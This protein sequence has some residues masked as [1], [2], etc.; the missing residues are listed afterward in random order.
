M[1]R[2]RKILSGISTALILGGLSACGET[3]PEKLEQGVVLS[4]LDTSE[5][6]YDWVFSCLPELDSEGDLTLGCRNRWTYT[7]ELATKTVVFAGCRKVDGELQVADTDYLDRH[8]RNP[9]DYP[10]ISEGIAIDRS[11]E[12][13]VEKSCY[14]DVEIDAVYGSTIQA[15]EVVS[16]SSLNLHRI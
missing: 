9:S 12:P 11:Q 15:G 14:G 13:A 16:R 1:T 4:V 6:E 3:G 2:S 8:T 5:P 7:G 10:V